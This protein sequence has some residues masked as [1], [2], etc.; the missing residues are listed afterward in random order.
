LKPETEIMKDT[1]VALIT[2]LGRS[3]IGVIRLSGDES[4]FHHSRITGDDEF[5]P[6]PR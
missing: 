6:K 5:N 1:I 4:S 2:P 3:G